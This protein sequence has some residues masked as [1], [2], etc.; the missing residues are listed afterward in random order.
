[1]RLVNACMVPARTPS[2][3][4]SFPREERRAQQDWHLTASWADSGEEVCEA[5]Q[6]RYRVFA[7]EMGACLTPPAGTAPGLDVDR[8]DPFCDHLLVHACQSGRRARTTLVGTYRVLSPAAAQRAGGFYMDT[9]FDL[10]SLA[11]LRRDAVELG[12]SCVA[13]GWRSGAVIMVLW[14]ALGAYMRSH[15]AQT[16]IGS[17]SI[18]LPENLQ[19]VAQLWH[20]LRDSHL[21]PLAWRVRPYAGLPGHLADLTK[22]SEVAGVAPVLHSAATNPALGVSALALP[23]LIKGYLRCGARLL[24]PPALD[25]AFNTADL[26]LMLKVDDLAPRY[27]RHFLDR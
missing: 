23:P 10:A 19:R 1:M 21:V 5:Q 2:L 3:M 14:S 22:A 4:P 20:Q 15:G 27:R 18:A 11:L 16:M 26:P 9:E 17:A 25:L 24:G 6:L 7:L 12:R 8:F 13:P